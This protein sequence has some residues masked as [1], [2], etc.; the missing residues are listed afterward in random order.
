MDDRTIVAA[1]VAG[2][3]RGLD[4]AYRVYA[5]RLYTYCRFLLR[6]ADGAADAVHDTFVLAGQRAA[7]LR[8]PERLRPWLYAIARNECLRVIRGQRRQLPLDDVGELPATPVDPVTGLGAEQLRELVR[9]A[10][11]GLNPGDRQV[12]ELAIRHDLS[13]A[14]VGAVLGVSD[15]HAHARLSRARTQ[16]ERAIGA[17]LVARTGA[18]DCPTLGEL[19]RGWDGTLTVLL[20]KRVSRHIESCPTCADRRRRQV[21]PAALFSAYA[22][23][24]MLAV[25]A[26]LWPRLELTSADAGQAAT[27]ARIE[28]RAGR[29][30]PATGFPRRGEP[31]RGRL[32]AGLAAAAVLALLIGGAVVVPRLAT[33]DDTARSAPA[34]SPGLAAP[35]TTP[36][37]G[38]EPTATPGEPAP[39]MPT[40]TAS[41][42]G[43]PEPT[44]SAG[45]LPLT[46]Q[47][48]ARVSCTGSSRYQLTVVATVTGGTVESAV[49]IWTSGAAGSTQP[50]PTDPTTEPGS[51]PES[52]SGPGAG[53]PGGI[54]AP[55]G[56]PARGGEV[57]MTVSGGT[58]TGQVGQVAVPSV[59]WQ[60]VV[61]AADGRRAGAGPYP[62]ANPCPVPI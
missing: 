33:V 29:F 7:Q 54:A 34:E 60:V 38:S 37:A 32:L 62:V 19:L 59:D 44:G 48:E 13:A 6:D 43:G 28:Q 56:V 25:P 18:D 45:P 26:E 47:A 40:A 2:D 8:D 12:I 9:S 23:L 39:T 55:G 27:R 36:S 3:P 24:P 57:A 51:D 49:L 17:L 53:G 10:A 1:L 50:P 20:R 41:A 42:G 21:S 14:D 4:R 11:A 31:R 46:V 15:S 58:A 52:T 30:D 61:V 5:D 35:P 16:L 22:T